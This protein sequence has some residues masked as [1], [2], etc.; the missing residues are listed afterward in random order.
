MVQ[1]FVNFHIKLPSCIDI[2]SLW[3]EHINISTY[4]S[5]LQRIPLIQNGAPFHPEGR[6]SGILSSAS[7]LLNYAK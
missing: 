2:A 1:V 6:T 3:L 4:L 5:N 7:I